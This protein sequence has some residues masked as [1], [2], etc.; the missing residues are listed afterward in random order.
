MRTYVLRSLRCCRRAVA[1]VDPVSET[2]PDS[3]GT[4]VS[5]RRC[6]W[7]DLQVWLEVAA[8]NH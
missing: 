6:G 4:P 2:A 1:Q 3:E 8:V 7:F 5:R